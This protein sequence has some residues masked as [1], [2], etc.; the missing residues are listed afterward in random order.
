[1]R[2][3]YF[4]PCH[5]TN[6][7]KPVHQVY[8]DAGE[9]VEF[10]DAAGFDCIWFPEHH[11]TQKFHSVAPL[12]SAVDAAR[13]TTRARVGTSVILTPYHH[14]LLLAEQIGLAD[15]LTEGRLETGFARG[16]YVYEYQ[17]LG[18]QTEIEAGER[19]RECLEVLLGVWEKDQDFAYEGKYYRFPPV[20]PVPRPYQEPHPPIWVAARS[21]ETLRFAVEHGL[22]MQTTPLREPMTRVIGQLKLLDAIVEEL[23]APGRPPLAVQRETFVAEDP[24]VLGRALDHAWQNHVT[25]WHQHHST[26]RIQRGFTPLDPLPDGSVI[27]PDE[28]ANRLVVGDPETCVRRLLE[29]EAL[30]FDEYILYLDFGQDQREV[31]G[32]LRLF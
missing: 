22:G 5:H 18:I 14:P 26:A 21:A 16:S 13:R 25:S 15:H 3:S 10:V 6:P 29:Y 1:M 19:Q 17:R 4:V 2:F 23:G 28:L 9:Q 24:K 27:P 30:G 32:S 8:R 12:L 20:Y 31:M 7:G 11:F